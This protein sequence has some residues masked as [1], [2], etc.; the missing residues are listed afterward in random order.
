MK[1]R[2]II[3][4]RLRNIVQVANC[5]VAR[6]L[7]HLHAISAAQRT[8]RRAEYQ[9]LIYRQAHGVSFVRLYFCCDDVDLALTSSSP[10]FI[11]LFSLNDSSL[12]ITFLYLSLNS[13]YLHYLC[14]IVLL[15]LYSLSLRR[16]Q[17]AEGG[18]NI[19]GGLLTAYSSC[20]CGDRLRR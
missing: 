4:L 13:T 8:P 5:Q 14:G 11:I 18:L 10:L 19:P 20:C 16:T 2:R 6:I 12:T 17:S 15:L 3:V 9:F 7:R 1:M